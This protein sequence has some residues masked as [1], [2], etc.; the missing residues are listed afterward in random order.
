MRKQREVLK[1]MVMC[2]VKN[3]KKEKKR[4]FKCKA[5]SIT[6]ERDSGTGG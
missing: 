3:K 4:I 5:H 1:M 6:G 2:P